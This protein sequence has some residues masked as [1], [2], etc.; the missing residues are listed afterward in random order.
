MRQDVIHIL[1]LYI[2]RYVSEGCA[3]HYLILP[4][5]KIETERYILNIVRVFYLAL[6][7]Y[8]LRFIHIVFGNT[9]P[10]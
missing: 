5:N 8:D 2:F 3:I 10:E 7:F 9:H 6:F 1:F 4:S